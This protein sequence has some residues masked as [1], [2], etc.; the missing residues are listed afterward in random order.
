MFNRQMLEKQLTWTG[1]PSFAVMF[2]AGSAAILSALIPDL[3]TLTFELNF[4]KRIVCHRHAADTEFV[5]GCAVEELRKIVPT[6]VEYF[7]IEEGWTLNDYVARTRH[8]WETYRRG[9]IPALP[10]VN[11]DKLERIELTW[12]QGQGLVIGYA[13]SD[14]LNS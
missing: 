5:L 11:P 2:I 1:W 9:E 4:P 10:E 13:Y 12:F 7:I 3:H 6:P 8:L 14:M